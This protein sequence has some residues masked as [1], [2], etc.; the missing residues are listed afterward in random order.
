MFLV[1]FFEFLKNMAKYDTL[2]KLGL[3]KALTTYR[4]ELH[5]L[6]IFYLIR[7]SLPL[8]LYLVFILPALSIKKKTLGK[9]IFT[10]HKEYNIYRSIQ[11]S[12]LDSEITFN[13]SQLL[14]RK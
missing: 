1:A 5:V 13:Q 11:F 4:R 10:L 2:I 6:F 9:H 14:K 3:D 7:F 12:A 8:S